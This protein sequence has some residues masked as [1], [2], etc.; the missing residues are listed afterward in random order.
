MVTVKQDTADLGNKLQIFYD[1]SHIHIYNPDFV[2]VI[3]II[4]LLCRQILPHI[5]DT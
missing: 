4:F 3:V 5:E 2:A 1:F